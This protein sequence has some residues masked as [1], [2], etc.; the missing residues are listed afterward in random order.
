MMHMFTLSDLIQEMYH[1]NLRKT[2]NDV[3]TLAA[4]WQNNLILPS[5]K[6]YFTNLGMK[7]AYL[8][9]CFWCAEPARNGV[10][11]NVYFG[12]GSVFP[13][14][15]TLDQLHNMVELRVVYPSCVFT[16]AHM[17]KSLMRKSHLNT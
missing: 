17:R 4:H 10:F 6:T 2:H 9:H 12:E 8:T 15:K 7:A 3:A 13:D 5:E 16:N 11:S 14:S 1:V